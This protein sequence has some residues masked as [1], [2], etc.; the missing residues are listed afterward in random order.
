[1]DL[2]WL[3]D[4]LVLLEEGNM[5]RAAMRRHITQPAFSRRIRS[6]EGWLGTD[7]LQ[8]GANSVEISPAL[9]ANEPELRAL[10]ARIR[11]LRSKI[12][13]FDPAS[14]TVSL[15]AQ[16]APVFSVFPDMALHAQQKFPALKFRLRP[17][18]LRDCVTM[19]LRGDANMLL[20]YESETVGP[21]PFGPRIRRAIWGDDFLVPVIGGALRSSL[22]D[23][24]TLPRNTPAI[25]YPENSY[26]GEVLNASGRPFATRAFSENP[27]CETAFSSGIKQLVLAGMGVGWLPHSMSFSE[28]ESG[29]LISLAHHLGEEQ[30]KIALYAD[31]RDAVAMSLLEVW[32]AR[33]V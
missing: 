1:M 28:I 7:V 20:C 29:E 21:M 33:A 19:F 32:S 17:G 13:H 18:N 25:I 10:I 30:L 16:H 4:V 3:D 9:H 11:D 23:D 2:K 22:C 6:F 24:G 27:F 15:A 8:R 31:V 26:F 14:S 12:A 5:S